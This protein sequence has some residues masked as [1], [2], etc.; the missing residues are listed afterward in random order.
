VTRTVVGKQTPLSALTDG[1]L[2]DPDGFYR[3]AVR[4]ALLPL[5]AEWR[6]EALARYYGAT[7]RTSLR[8]TTLGFTELVV[9][10]IPGP[11]LEAVVA[12]LLAEIEGA[13]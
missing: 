13:S 1:A 8:R 9:T 6:Q 12:E 3:G 10:P 11:T 7:T 4:E 5:P 2:A